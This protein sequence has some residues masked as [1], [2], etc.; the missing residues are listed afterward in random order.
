[1]YFTTFTLKMTCYFCKLAKTFSF[2]HFHQK[3]VIIID[4]AFRG[5]NLPIGK[6]GL[7]VT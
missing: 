7:L 4:K 5:L 3:R 6:P 2:I 1:M